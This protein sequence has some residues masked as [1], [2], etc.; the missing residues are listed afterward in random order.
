LPVFQGITWVDFNRA[1]DLEIVYV[2]STILVCHMLRV[3]V[4]EEKI[5]KK[6]PL[7]DGAQAAAFKGPVRTAL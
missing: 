2:I 5:L 4:C 6:I 1:E 3:E 7:K